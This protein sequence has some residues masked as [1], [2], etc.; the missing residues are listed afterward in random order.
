MNQTI[1]ENFDSFLWLVY[2]CGESQVY[3][4]CSFGFYEVNFAER[5]SLNVCVAAEKTLG[6]IAV[7]RGHAGFMFCYLEKCV[8]LCAS[9]LGVKESKY[10]KGRFNVI[11]LCCPCVSGMKI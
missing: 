4:M 9:V 2:T 6:R 11:E 3:I 7:N 10:S 8:C 1:N 5:R